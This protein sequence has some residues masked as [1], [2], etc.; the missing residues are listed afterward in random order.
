M[1]CE[2]SRHWQTQINISRLGGTGQMRYW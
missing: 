2:S 1:I